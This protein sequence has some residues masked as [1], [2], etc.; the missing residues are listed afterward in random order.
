MKDFIAKPFFINFVVPFIAIFITGLL[1]LASRAI[2]K[3]TAEDFAFGLDITVTSM[4]LLVT[5]Y[6]KL[7][8][9]TVGVSAPPKDLVEKL[10]EVPLIMVAFLVGLVGASILMRAKGLGQSKS[11]FSRQEVFFGVVLPDILGACS[12]LFVVNWINFS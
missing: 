12:L 1:K 6:P 3:L 2:I 11:S 9:L 4:L 8:K 7:L 5:E 10:A